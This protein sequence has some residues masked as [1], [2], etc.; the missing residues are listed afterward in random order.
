M[1]K[2]KRRSSKDVPLPLLRTLVQQGLSQRQMLAAV[3]EQGFEISQTTLRNRL[4]EI[5][6]GTIH[7]ESC[8]VRK[9]TAR[10]E[11]YISRLIRI[12]KLRSAPQLQR[13]MQK[14]G[15]PKKTN[16]RSIHRLPRLIRASAN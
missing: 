3:Q 5:P 13:E 14:M 11:R 1:T 6:E 7:W 16:M 15:K 8:H 10:N 2:Y 9:L 4:A 12:N